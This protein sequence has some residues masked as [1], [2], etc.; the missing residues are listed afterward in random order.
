M[1]G[2]IRSIDA[3]YLRIDTCKYYV[4]SISII[5]L[6]KCRV[7]SRIGVGEQRKEAGLAM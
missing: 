5:R 2:K 4:V 3:E 1:F 6:V 7:S